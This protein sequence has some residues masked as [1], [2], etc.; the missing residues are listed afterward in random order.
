MVIL[1]KINKIKTKPVFAFKVQCPMF[2]KLMVLSEM[3]KNGLNSCLKRSLK[4]VYQSRIKDF[5]WVG[6]L[7]MVRA[8]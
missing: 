4:L 8:E 2:V 7:L 1:D 3:Y 6:F 5:M